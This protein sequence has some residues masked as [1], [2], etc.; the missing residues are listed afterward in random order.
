MKDVGTHLVPSHGYSEWIFPPWRISFILS[1]IPRAYEL[2]LIIS[3]LGSF[4]SFASRRNRIRPSRLFAFFAGFFKSQKYIFGISS[5]Y[6]LAIYAYIYRRSSPF[7]L[8]RLS[9]SY[10]RCALASEKNILLPPPF[11]FLSLYFLNLYTRF[12]GF[13]RLTPATARSNLRALVHTFLHYSIGRLRGSPGAPNKRASL[14]SSLLSSLLAF[15]S[16]LF[17]CLSRFFFPSLQSF[18][19]SSLA[20]TPSHCA[21]HRLAALMGT[22]L[23]PFLSL[24]LTVLGERAG[25]RIYG[26]AETH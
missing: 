7:S 25:E 12:D 5:A 20:N 16:S 6:P 17:L 24:F 13:H 23:P 19:V 4:L 1:S 18:P 2:S 14:F 10:P 15:F 9:T 3:L 22:C 8:P 26:R 21:F 11:L